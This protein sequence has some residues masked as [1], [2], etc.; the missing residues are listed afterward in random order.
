M[1]I[2]WFV[3]WCIHRKEIKNDPESNNP[4]AWTHDVF[5]TFRGGCKFRSITPTIGPTTG[6]NK[7]INNRNR[8]IM[9]DDTVISV[10]IDEVVSKSD[11]ISS[12]DVVVDNDSSND[13]Y[14]GDIPSL[15]SNSK[16]KKQKIPSSLTDLS[17]L[18]TSKKKKKISTPSTDL[19]RKK[20]IPS[21]VIDLSNIPKKNIQKKTTISSTSKKKENDLSQMD[22]L[23]L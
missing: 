10:D 6:Y 16:K 19:S 8:S 14:N 7:Y 1:Y 12:N 4:L 21:S 9:H 11:I 18:P 15:V 5:R 20:K 2:C 23:M 13:K 22:V 17:N 3:L